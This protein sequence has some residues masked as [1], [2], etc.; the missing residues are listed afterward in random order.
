MTDARVRAAER[1]WRAD[2][3][4]ENLDAAILEAR[5]S[6]VRV[7]GEW[8]LRQTFPRRPFTCDVAGKVRVE[9][10]RGELQSPKGTAK[11][12]PIPQH[13]M[14]WFAPELSE[15]FT[16]AKLIALVKQESI[17]GLSLESP[18]LKPTDLAELAKELPDLLGLMLTEMH[19]RW[20]VVGFPENALEPFA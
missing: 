6:G 11:P 1:R 8:L 10:A 14:W 17:P 3:S 7:P 19:A 16:L 13:H 5:R 12:V 20:E 15:S 4:P 9:N 2:P 18:Q